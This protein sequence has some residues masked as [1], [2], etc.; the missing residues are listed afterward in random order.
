[1]ELQKLSN[2]NGS[3]LNPVPPTCILIWSPQMDTE[4]QGPTGT[5]QSTYSLAVMAKALS[6]ELAFG[7]CVRTWSHWEPSF[8]Q[9]P[10]CMEPCFFTLWHLWLYCS[11]L[12]SNLTAFRVCW[13]GGRPGAQHSAAM[14]SLCS[15]GLST[16][17]TKHCQKNKE[18]L[19]GV[20]LCTSWCHFFNFFPLF[21]II[22][23]F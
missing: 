12:L 4:L 6:G 16:N 7:S 22:P 15:F 8:L 2:R 9:P 23:F 19:G 20:S 11:Y 5:Q 14:W 13:T 17:L 1:M 10:L 21:F 3:L 18:L